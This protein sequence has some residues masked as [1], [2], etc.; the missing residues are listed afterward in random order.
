MSYYVHYRSTDPA[1][2]LLGGVRESTSS[3]F[4]HKLDADA[5]LACIIAIHADLPRPLKVEGRIAISTLPA[6]I[7]RHCN[8]DSVPQ[9]VGCICFECGKV[10]QAS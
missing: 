2:T 6:E 9:A 3:R 4:S 5:R 7:V 1:R 8:A 10:V